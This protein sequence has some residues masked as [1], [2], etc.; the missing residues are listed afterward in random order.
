MF[1]TEKVMLVT[2][3]GTFS[4]LC[5]RTWNMRTELK[6]ALWSYLVQFLYFI[7]NKNEIEKEK[8]KTYIR[9]KERFLKFS[10]SQQWFIWG[11]LPHLGFF[12]LLQK[13]RWMGPSV[14]WVPADIYFVMSRKQRTNRA[15]NTLL[16]DGAKLLEL[17]QL[18]FAFY[19][20]SNTIKH[21]TYQFLNDNCHFEF[22]DT[23]YKWTLQNLFY[24]F[25]TDKHDW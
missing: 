20:K 14:L 25:P 3:C 15:Q 2:L 17:A 19:S 23:E 6:G 1:S 5:S 18:P 7:T 11:I 9:G 21:W 13:W 4:I 10:L 22:E 12:L 16:N 8:G 24:L